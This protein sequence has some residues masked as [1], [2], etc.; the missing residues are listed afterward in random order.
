[1]TTRELFFEYLKKDGKPDRQLKQ[2]EAL[3]LVMNDPVNSYLRAGQL[4][5][6]VSKDRWGTTIAF[7]KDAPGKTP[8]ITEENKVC[9]DIT[10]W[11]DYVHAP[12]L[13]AHCKEGWETCKETAKEVRAEGKLVTTLMGTGIFEQCHFLMGFEDT[14]TNLY[15]HPQEMH[16]LIDYIFEYRLTFAKLICENLHPDVILSHDDWGTKHAL[17][18]Q[19]ETW[20]E[21]FKEPYRKFYSYIRSQ[22]VVA[23]HH[24]DS[25][26]MPIV[27]DMVEIGIQV[28]QGALPEN[29]IPALLKQLDGRMAVMGGIGAVIDRADT[30]K[31][32]AKDYVKKVLEESCP[33]GHFIPCITYGAPG[34]VFKQVDPFIDE[35]IEEYNQK[36]HLPN[37]RSAM[38]VRRNTN[39]TMEVLLEKEEMLEEEGPILEKIAM[40]IRKGQ[41]KKVLDLCQEA[42][43]EG[44]EA[45]EILSQGLVL[46][47][48]RLGEDF[49]A[50]KV[51]VPEML[52]AAR[53]MNQAT[54]LL[55]SQLVGTANQHVGKVCLGTV[56]GDMHDIGKNLVKVMM[57]GNGLEVIDLGTDVD[58]QTFVETAVK[59]HCDII[60]CSSLLTTTM[61]EMKNVVELAKE[62]KIRDQIKIFVGGAPISQEFCD[63]IGADVYTEDAA[64]AAREAV[65][66]LTA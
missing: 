64:E 29:N 12:D 24:S 28:W 15:E 51:F 38:P 27:E 37:F 25:Y 13:L 8:H 34:T 36:Y 5:G 7:P 52:I 62:K 43:E 54:A 17:F 19:P 57:E 3:K 1:M 35:A 59:E 60:A 4:P 46:G 56:K 20:R 6:T 42:L 48:T 61:L 45:Q 39:K 18:M 32:V 50:N 63:E 11:R 31:E 58:A 65:R 33:Y 9:K 2:Y 47:M 23:I 26:C 22:G 16:E 21:F 49:S 66:I 44:L 53:C 30:T 40:A 55:K 10:H 41:K 14:L